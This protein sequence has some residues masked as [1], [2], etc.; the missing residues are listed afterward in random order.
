MEGIIPFARKDYR[1]ETKDIRKEQSEEREGE[2]VELKR[3]AEG[4]QL[5]RSGTDIK[6]GDVT[7]PSEDEMLD[8]WKVGG[9][10]R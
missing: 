6:R 2:F 1:E 3:A 10:H 7:E 9:A 8:V 4:S 5:Q